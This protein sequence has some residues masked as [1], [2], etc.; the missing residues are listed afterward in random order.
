MSVRK[1]GSQEVKHGR[2]QGRIQDSLDR[3]CQLH[4]GGGTPTYYFGHFPRKLY[5]IEKQMD[6]A[7]GA[8][9]L[10]APPEFHNAMLWFLLQQNQRL[11]RIV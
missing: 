1:S 11:E 8:C 10:R 6:Q 3:G 2:T 9:V 4:M 5:E 7:E